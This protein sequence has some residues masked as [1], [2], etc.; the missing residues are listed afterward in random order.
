MVGIAADR[1]RRRP[2][3]Y[4]ARQSARCRRC[5]RGCRR[6]RCRAPARSRG[7][8][9]DSRRT[10]APIPS[11]PSPG[12]RC[13][14]VLSR[15]SSVVSMAPRP[16]T[17]MLPP[18]STTRCGRPSTLAVGRHSGRRRRRATLP[19][20]VASFCQSGYLAQALKRQMVIAAGSLGRAF[21]DHEDGS[22]VAGPATIG[23]PE[24]KVQSFGVHMGVTQDLERASASLGIFHNDGDTFHPRQVADNL[25]IYPGDG[26]EF[27]R[28]VAAVVRPGQPGGSVR[29]PFGGHAVAQGRGNC[30]SRFTFHVSRR[31]HAISR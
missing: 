12:L 31:R 20:I 11:A 27:S 10:P 19:A 14:V 5:G 24:V 29:L 2:P 9:R 26:G 21:R 15:H 28:P 23:W 1:A 17:S 22:A 13:C 30:V 4:P 16:F 8:R 25:G 3:P 7:A 18:S 6:R